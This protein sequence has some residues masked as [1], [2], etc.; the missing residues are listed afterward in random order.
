MHLAILIKDKRKKKKDR[1]TAGYKTVN[2]KIVIT[3]GTAEIFFKKTGE[4][5]I[6][7]LLMN[8]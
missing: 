4:Y 5:F 3:I 7:N 2:K 6:I 1:K 8:I